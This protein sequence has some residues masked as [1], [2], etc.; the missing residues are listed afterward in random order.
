[1]KIPFSGWKTAGEEKLMFLLKK[2]KDSPEGDVKPGK[3]QK[4]KKDKKEA[5]KKGRPVQVISAG[6]LEE[7]EETGANDNPEVVD[8]EVVSED[9]SDKLLV[10]VEREPAGGGGTAANKAPTT[11][12]PENKAGNPAGGETK[13]GQGAGE[14][15]LL[16][17][18]FS[19]V[20][21]E[22]ET[23]LDRL[24]ASLPDVTIKEVLKEAEEVRGL[25]NEW[26]QNNLER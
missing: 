15:S 12:T 23:P 10:K 1:M 3:P 16:A 9:D 6:A 2:K 8:G 7:D 24:I 17:N 22:E 25:I 18:I 5:G 13:P 14:Q 4:Q 19:N 20:V 11:A 21:E 26:S